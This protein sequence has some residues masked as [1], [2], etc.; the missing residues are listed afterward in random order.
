MPHADTIT[1][2]GR[3]ILTVLAGLAQSERHLGARTTEGRKRARLMACCLA[4][5]AR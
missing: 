4:A 1:P 3:L 5:R 2:Y